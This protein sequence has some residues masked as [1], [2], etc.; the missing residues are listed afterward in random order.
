MIRRWGDKVVRR[1]QIFTYT[2][3]EPWGDR[4]KSEY[5]GIRRSGKNWTRRR[6]DTELRIENMD[7]GIG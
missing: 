2:D 5:Q 1:N 3:T 4:E 6:G 7:G